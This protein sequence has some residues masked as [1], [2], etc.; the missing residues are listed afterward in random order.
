ML[1]RLRI[2][3]ASDECENVIFEGN[4]FRMCVWVCWLFDPQLS[5]ALG[6]ITSFGGRKF[7][8]VGCCLVIRV[9]S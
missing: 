2:P 4:V 6:I 8:I 1:V 7:A 5:V 9:E 3:Y